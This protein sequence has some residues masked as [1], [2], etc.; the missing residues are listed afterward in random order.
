[1]QDYL[2]QQVEARQQAWHQAKELLDRAAAEKR[3]LSGEEE[4]SYGRIM[5]DLDQRSAR[6]EELRAEVQRQADID[7]SVR[8]I[9]E[10]R[11]ETSSMRSDADILRSLALGEIRAHTFEKRTIDTA[12]DSQIVPQSF[13]DQIQ[14]LMQFAGPMMDPAVV[15]VLNTASGEDIKVPVQSTRPAA[16]AIAEATTI[17]DL[18]PAFTSLTLKSQKIAVLTK[19]SREMIT[20]T[21]IDLVGFLGRQL[22]LAIGIKANNLLTVGTG[23]VQSNGIAN[24][25]GSALTGTATG[26]AFT[27]DNLI[28]LVHA[29]DSA[30]VRMGAGFQMRRA[31]VGS[32]RALKDNSGRYLFEPAATVGSPDTLLGYPIYENPDVAAVAANAK[33]VLFGWHGSYHT[34]MVGGIDLARSEDAYFGSDEIG[35][36]ATLRV[37]GDLGQADAVK[38][39]KGGT[40]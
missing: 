22:G 30:Y 18:D 25:A 6:I 31:A 2:K 28:T 23:T 9:P 26:G 11:T 7:A 4:Q 35:F 17:S 20:D 15:T 21:G 5:A 14:E 8:S 38:Y 3:D 39:F 12:N 40:A 27:A 24:A 34:R 36:R 1:M 32:V 13:Y 33:S 10:I 29:V 37:W 16:T 19:V